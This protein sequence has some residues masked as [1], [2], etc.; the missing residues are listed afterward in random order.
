MAI[1]VKKDEWGEYAYDSN[2]RAVESGWSRQ[3]ERK[4]VR[5]TGKTRGL[6][7]AIAGGRKTNGESVH[8][9]VVTGQR[10]PVEEDKESVK[11]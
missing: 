3:R 2:Y 4:K 11:R 8:L 5:G 6:R 10:S 1:A 7:M 9:T